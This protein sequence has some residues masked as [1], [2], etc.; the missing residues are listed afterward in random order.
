[1]PSPASQTSGMVDVSFASTTPQIANGM[2]A[3]I[4]FTALKGCQTSLA[5]DTAA[6]VIRNESGFAASVAGI[7]INRNPI[8]LNI[9]TAAGNPQPEI[10]GESVLP[11]APTIFP[12]GK[13]INWRVVTMLMLTIG[14]I[15]VIILLFK[16]A[17]PAKS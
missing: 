11:L 9:D 7:N 5:I 10:S 13:P 17:A 2:L 16:F 12:D 15:A 6:L 4:R 14:I 1:M 8:T 3:E